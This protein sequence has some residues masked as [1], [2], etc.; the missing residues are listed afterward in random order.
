MNLKFNLSDQKNMFKSSFK[1]FRNK[2]LSLVEYFSQTLKILFRG[3]LYFKEKE[4]R[5]R[6]TTKRSLDTLYIIRRTPPGSGLFSNFHLVLSHVMFALKNEYDFFIDYENYSN[7]YSE[8][9]PINDQKNSWNYYF[10]QPI[11]QIIREKQKYRRIIYS[12]ES[13]YSSL[14]KDYDI[15]NSHSLEF[16]ENIEQINLYKKIFQEHLNFNNETISHLESIKKSIFKNKKN[17]LGISIRGTDYI[18][19]KYPGHYIPPNIEEFCLKVDEFLGEFNPD[20]IFAST[21]DSNYL[22]HLKKRY[23]DKLVYLEKER[24]SLDD[25]P[26]FE[27]QQNK[28]YLNG[29]NYLTE[30]WLLSQSNH[31]IGSPNGGFNAAYIIKKSNFENQYIFNLGKY[32]NTKGTFY[33][34]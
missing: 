31:I 8:K 17:I 11:N 32:P 15:L 29:L 16:L 25:I 10:T 7:F 21:E 20:L 12:Q 33:S 30:I 19:N 13:I 26:M 1:H 34:I 9:I 23:K 6:H 18:K 22:D 5:K 3:S 2:R 4:V 24:Y 28:K 27:I 14:F